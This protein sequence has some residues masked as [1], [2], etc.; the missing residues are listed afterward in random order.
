MAIEEAGDN[1]H[2]ARLVLEKDRLVQ[3]L[4]E[5]ASETREKIRQLD[6]AILKESRELG[7]LK[8]A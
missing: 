7:Q 4:K 5:F 6:A 8:F 1:K 2:I 3:N